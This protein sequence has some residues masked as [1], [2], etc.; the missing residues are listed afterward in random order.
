MIPFEEYVHARG[1]RLLHFAYALSGN[2]RVAEDLVHEVFAKGR[3]HWSRVD[4]DTPD[5]Y[6]R[7]ALVGG[8]L[9]VWRR[10]IP[11]AADHPLAKLT[12]VQR[13]VLVLQ[14]LNRLDDEEIA[15]CIGR[16]PA[17]VR[18]LAEQGLSQVDGRGLARAL[19]DFGHAASQRIGLLEGTTAKARQLSRR[20]AWASGGVA[21]GLIGAAALLAPTAAEQTAPDPSPSVSASP[22]QR[23]PAPLLPAA[24]T[25]PSFPYLP[26]YVPA[27][28]A[29][30][31]VTK[32]GS[33]LGVS[34]G[35]I[36]GFDFVVSQQRPPATSEYEAIMLNGHPTELRTRTA[37]FGLVV[38][39]SW[40]QDGK[41]ISFTANAK[42]L[43]EAKRIAGSLRPG[44]VPMKPP[45]FTITLAPPGFAVLAANQ[46]TVCLA[47]SRQQA[48]PV[49]DFFG[50]CVTLLDEVPIDRR[51]PTDPI[52]LT[53]AGVRAEFSDPPGLTSEL[54]IFVGGG[55]VL[56]VRQQP[57][58]PSAELLPDD[59]VRF[60][61]GVKIID[62]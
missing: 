39:L 56:Q 13:T 3:K 9:S 6:L 62:G 14:L 61:E 24:F 12:R 45:P 51:W 34:Y 10:N 5:A 8:Y 23:A 19:A 52:R 49:R 35:E 36:P 32:L 17:T 40:Q 55:R 18:K 27:D 11:V 30:P 28:A 29:P 31:M 25:L 47:E 42:T 15:D 50:L 26:S 20:R 4:A 7:Q 33:A 57:L 48:E 60:A 1:S 54:R 38:M 43:E 41:F 59:L 44:V 46:S 22:T 58:S 2:Q 37:D 21:V 53:V 16:R